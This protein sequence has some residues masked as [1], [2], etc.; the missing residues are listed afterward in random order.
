MSLNEA[1]TLWAAVQ[2]YTAGVRAAL[3]HRWQVGLWI[4]RPSL[5][6]AIDFGIVADRAQRSNGVVHFLRPHHEIQVDKNAATEIGCPLAHEDRSPLQ[7]G[8]IPASLRQ[9]TASSS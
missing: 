4:A 7:T 1:R 9:A 2:V 8:S 6:A 5:G 3:Q